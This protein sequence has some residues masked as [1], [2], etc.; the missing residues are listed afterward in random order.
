LI[1]RRCFAG[2][3]AARLFVSKVTMP[4]PESHPAK[5]VNYREKARQLR[6]VAAF[7]P[8]GA[9]RDQLANLA[10]QFDNLAASLESWALLP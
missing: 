4:G 5:A 8:I 6:E 9:C 2:E 7:E 10:L 1:D 3:R